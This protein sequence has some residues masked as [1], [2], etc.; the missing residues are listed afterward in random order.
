MVSIKHAPVQRSSSGPL[1]W[2]NY[3]TGHHGGLFPFPTHQTPTAGAQAYDWHE[4][5]R[6]RIQNTCYTNTRNRGIYTNKVLSSAYWFEDIDEGLRMEQ[7]QQRPV[8]GVKA[9]FLC[10]DTSLLS[11]LSLVTADEG[12][13]SVFRKKMS[14]PV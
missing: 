12:D 9:T 4:L 13:D 5:R 7:T 8:T 10:F 14:H 11:Y 2:Q 3:Y 1:F 6:L